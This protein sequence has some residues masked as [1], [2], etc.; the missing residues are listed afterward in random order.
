MNSIKKKLNDL[1]KL[2]KNTALRVAK[3]TTKQLSKLTKQMK[4]IIEPVMNAIKNIIKTM[5]CAIKLVMNI[6]K[7]FIFY[8]LDMIKY[9]L[10][11]LPILLLMSMVGLS[12]EWKPLQS[13]LDKFISW[14][15]STQNQCYR[16][17]DKQMKKLGFFEKLKKMMK[18]NKKKGKS[19]FHFFYFLLVCSVG[20]ALVY[21]SWYKL[22]KFPIPK[23][24]LGFIPHPLK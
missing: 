2:P 6:P 20:I 24:N 9:T 12:K 11:Y 10:M 21:F 13:T 16:C 4:K 1:K 5:K 3:K 8:F 15:N 7:C 18:K 14:P 17:K 23:F 19:S 22:Q